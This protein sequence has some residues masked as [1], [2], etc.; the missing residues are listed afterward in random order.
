[1]STFSFSSPAYFLDEDDP[2]GHATV[3]VNRTGATGG[4][5]SVDYSTSDGTA[6]L[7]GA[8]YNAATGTLN[9][10]AG[11][12]SKTFDVDVSD[13]SADEA[14]ETVNLALT[15]GATT[16]AS[17]LLSIVDDDNPKAS[18]QLAS[19]TYDVN[20]ADG[21]ADVTVTLNHAVDA[22]VT[23]NYATTDGTAAA[24]SDFTDTD[25]TLTFAGNVSNAGSGETSKTIHIPIA[26]DPDPEDPETLTLTLSNA[27]P[28]ASSILGAPATGTITIADDDAPGLI[29]FKELHYDAAESDGQATVTVQRLGGVGGAVSVDYAT[30]DGSATAGSDYTV[31]IGTLQWAAGDSADKTFNV[32]VSWDA[33]AEGAESINLELTNPGGGAE[34]GAVAAAIVRVAD[35]GASGPLALSAGAYR[36]GE[37]GG[38]VTITVKRSGGSLG[39]PVKVDYATKNGTATAGSDYAAA[40]G[41]LSFGTGESAKSFTVPVSSDS[42]DESDETFQVTLSG[43][44]GGANLGSPAGATVTIADDDATP[45][46]SPIGPSGTDTAAP[47]LTLGA[48]RIQRALKAK[49]LRFSARCSEQCKLAATARV[50]MGGKKVLLGRVKA[51]AA[52]D[53]TTKLKL[54]LSKKALRKLRK[55]TR[56]GKARVFLKV[57][58]ADAAANRTTASRKIAVKR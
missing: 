30:S 1:M 14:N 5:A 21:T 23:V 2:A 4:P 56:R 55:A 32:P 42:A 50:R 41:T 18:V 57:S 39:G 58:A 12:T 37:S 48:K 8:D 20:E 47:K 28:G 6:T 31:T 22:D 9:F 24:G 45:G 33:R 49:A 25:G 38:L 36:V 46:G 17:S 51:S 11:E 13:D 35:D 16:L 7:A 3:T 43:A 26:Q 15:S 10:S 34:L 44:G 40:T 27:L 54:K 29:D 53:Q 52:S 19:P